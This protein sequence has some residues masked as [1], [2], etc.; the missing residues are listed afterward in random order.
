MKKLRRR[1]ILHFSLQFILL[2]ISM[3]LIIIVLFFVLLIFITNKEY[4]TNELQATIEHIGTD[5]EIKDGKAVIREEWDDILSEKGLWLQIINED[6]KLVASR[7]APAD[8]PEQYSL[9]DMVKIQKTNELDKYAVSYYLETFYKQSYLFLLGYQDAS[10]DLLEELAESYSQDGMLVENTERLQSSME[11]MN[12]TLHIYSRKDEL[13]FTAGKLKTELEDAPLDVFMRMKAPNT[14]ETDAVSLLF[15]KSG[16]TW[17]LYTANETEKVHKMNTFREIIMILGILTA[18]VLACT[19]VIAFWNGFKYGHPLLLFTNWLD[20]MGEGLYDQVITKQ[21][22][23]RIFKR[24]GK[25]RRKYRLYQEVFVAFNDM[26]EKLRNTEQ[27]RKQLDRTRE[28]WMAGISHDLRTPLSTIQGY[29]HLFESGNFNWTEEELKEIG[30]TVR[31][32]SDYMLNLIEDFSLS[33]RLKND[34]FFLASV[35]TEMNDF[36]MKV[37]GKY[38]QDH[39]L[40]GH[41][42]H[43]EGTS[44]DVYAHIDLILFERLLDN[45]IYNSFT[46][47][48]PGTKIDVSLQLHDGMLNVE[49]RDNGKGMDQETIDKLFT[50][51]YRGTNTE[52]RTEGTGLGMSIAKQIAELHGGNIRV[53]SKLGR[54][55]IVTFVLPALD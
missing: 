52:E 22:Q 49:V 44:S 25:M 19:M 18:L 32:K 13:V 12:A 14:Y 11:K 47:N 16:Y 7:N 20:R 4:Q 3:A 54:G 10:A 21:E 30:K 31:E 40:S 24:N 33:F 35:E 51:Y 37:I 2:A 53:H 8:L 9:I 6:G 41:P 1:L 5:T 36:I 28:E 17:V 29:G 38:K 43:F 26:A 39:M 27:E 45:M 34:R 50:R 46:H 48:P 55:T 42:I 23:K 15:P